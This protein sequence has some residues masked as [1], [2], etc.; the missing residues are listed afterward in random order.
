M[1]RAMSSTMGAAEADG[2]GAR[3]IPLGDRALLERHRGGDRA[4][5]KEL[6]AAFRAPV[7]GYLTRCGVNPSDRDDLFQEVFLRVHRAATDAPPVGPVAPWL[8]AIA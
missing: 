7:Y 3:V 6:V 1:V 8:F 2:A 4:A 5:F